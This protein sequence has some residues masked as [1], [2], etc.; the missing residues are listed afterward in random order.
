VDERDCAVLQVHAGNNNKN[1]NG[2]YWWPSVPSFSKHWRVLKYR[3]RV[4][5][6]IDCY[7]A[8]RDAC[9]DW[10]FVSSRTQK[11]QG[12][13]VIK[14]PPYRWIH[15]RQVHSG[16][17]YDVVHNEILGDGGVQFATSDF[18]FQLGPGRRLATYTEASP[19]I[20]WLPKLYVFSPVRVVYDLVDERGPRTTFTSTAYATTKGHWLRGEERM[21]VA[22]RDDS[23][24]VDVELLSISQPSPGIGRLLWPF[25]GPFQTNFF[26][27]ELNAMQEVANNAPQRRTAIQQQQVDENLINN[28]NWLKI[29]QQQQREILRGR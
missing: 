18:A 19:N 11:D 5:Q 7:E 20:K 14:P 3:L 8:V 26:V 12:I 17:G 29:Q 2:D 15:P 10:Q 23:E 25:M 22:Y 21:T 27:S 6:G 9:L 16:K 4:G 13:V 24:A 28:R 1:N